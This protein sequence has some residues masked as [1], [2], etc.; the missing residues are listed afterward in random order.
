MSKVRRIC[1][2]GGEVSAGSGR[3]NAVIDDASGDNEDELASV[4]LDESEGDRISR[5]NDAADWIVSE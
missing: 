2:S 4:K 3:E 1:G 5:E